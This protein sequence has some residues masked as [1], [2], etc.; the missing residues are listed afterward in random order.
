MR[1]ID[2]R[3]ADSLKMGVMQ[4]LNLSS[5][6]MNQIFMTIYEDTEKE[7][8]EWVRDYVSD[9][10]MDETLE[11]IQMF[12]LPRRLNETD[13]KANFNLEQL[14][15]EET[16]FSNFF[17]KHNVS[18]KE[19]DGHINLYNKGK[20]QPL[21]DEFWY[22]GGNIYYLRSRLGHNSMVHRCS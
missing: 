10:V 4:L 19:E 11:Y 9:Y 21:D 22:S 14:L 3:T 15:L 5:S 2:T 8:W 18:F 1:Y 20:L 6:E 16:T 17:K 13:L 7:P 12:H